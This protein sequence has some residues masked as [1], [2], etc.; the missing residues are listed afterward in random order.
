[1]ALLSISETV[2][3]GSLHV[4]KAHLHATPGRF[5]WLNETLYTRTGK[6]GGHGRALQIL[7]G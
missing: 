7:P 4:S 1:M 5:R 2:L 3:G 6:D